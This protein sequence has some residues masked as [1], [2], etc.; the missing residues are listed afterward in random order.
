MDSGKIIY[1]PSFVMIDCHLK[2]D[3]GRCGRH[4]HRQHGGL[5]SLLIFSKKGNQ[6]TVRQLGGSGSKDRVKKFKDK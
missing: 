5:I 6:A 4:K 3:C 2:A 1:I